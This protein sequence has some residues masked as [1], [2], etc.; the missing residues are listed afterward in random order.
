MPV[1]RAL[2]RPG[3]LPEPASLVIVID[4]RQSDGAHP[5]FNQQTARSSPALAQSLAFALVAAFVATM[6][7]RGR[8]DYMPAGAVA[9]G[10]AATTGLGGKGALASSSS[11]GSPARSTRS[12]W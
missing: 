6:V 4:P 5:T 10:A 9:P 1:A 12:F 3:P 11:S 7:G 8:S 2:G